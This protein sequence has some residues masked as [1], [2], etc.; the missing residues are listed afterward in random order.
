M[1]IHLTLLIFV[2]VALAVLGA[3]SPRALAPWLALLGTL[4]PLVYGVLLLLDF[5]Y[6]RG[7][8]QYVT[9]DAWID[10]LGIRYSLGVDGLNLWLVALTAL[11][12]RRPFWAPSWRRTWRC[13]S[14]SST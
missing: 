13:S 6:A 1:T 2:P 8:L 7:G 14:S 12:A 4:V 5:D 10:E 11:L 3:M 9:S